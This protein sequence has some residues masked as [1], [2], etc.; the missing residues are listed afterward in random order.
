MI[1]I[2]IEYHYLDENLKHQGS[3]SKCFTSISDFNSAYKLAKSDPYVIINVMKYNPNEFPLQKEMN[4]VKL[5]S[6]TRSLINEN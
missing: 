1:N 3:L 4:D 6:V 2:H 5:Y